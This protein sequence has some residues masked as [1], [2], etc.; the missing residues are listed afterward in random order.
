MKLFH[1]YRSSASYRVRIAL[2]LKGLPHDTVAVNLLA[3][4]QRGTAYAAVNPAQMVP[5]LE[6]GEL[7]L[8]QSLAILDYLDECHPE[9]PLLPRTAKE[10]ARVR[11]FAL[12]IACDIHPL[13][14]LRVLKYL[15]GPLGLDEAQKET[16][17][18]H[19]IN[20]GLSPLENALQAQSQTDRGPYCFGA[21]PGLA[22][23]V[24]IPQLYNA[25]RV[26]LDLQPFPR[27]LAVD[28][29]CQ[30]LPAFQS[31][32]PDRHSPPA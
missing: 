3:G 20:L 9:P 28:A 22:D 30:A 15:T 19:W 10:R 7:Q 23:C 25:R 21:L 14:N 18:R 6:D 5:I 1:Y 8:P 11:A 17:A 13:N 12:S 4:E 24:L 32:H 31:A 16:W 26:G 2:A 27:L 29:A